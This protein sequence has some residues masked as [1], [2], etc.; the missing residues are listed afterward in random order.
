MEETWWKNKYFIP[1]PEKHKEKDIGKLE[2]NEIILS[3][4]VPLPKICYGFH[5]FYWKKKE[6]FKNSISNLSTLGRKMITV[7]NPF[8]IKLTNYNDLS[9]QTKINEKY[10]ITH[11]DLNFYIFWEIVNEFNL[12][13]SK[14]N[15]NIL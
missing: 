15:I 10:Y 1:T 5:Y 7:V 11:S 6:D 8:E 14:S 13:E 4:S 12:L 3:V 2:L 9:I